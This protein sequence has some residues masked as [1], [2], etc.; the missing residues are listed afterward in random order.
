[1]ADFI[2]WWR[3]FNS[4]ALPTL[5]NID[6]KTTITKNLNRLL[7]EDVFTFRNL[8]NIYFDLSSLKKSEE[9]LIL[10]I[11]K[12]L[13]R[14]ENILN[15]FLAHLLFQA[16]VQNKL[17]LKSLDYSLMEKVIVYTDS[18]LQEFDS[19]Q[20]CSIFSCLPCLNTDFSQTFSTAYYLV[21]NLHVNLMKDFEK[22]DENNILFIIKAYA[23]EGSFRMPY[24]LLFEIHQS[25]C[26]IIKQNP[27]AFSSFFLAKYSEGFLAI[28]KNKGWTDRM[29]NNTV[30]TQIMERIPNDEVLLAF[31]NLEVFL[32]FLASYPQTDKIKEYYGIILVLVEKNVDNLY[33]IYNILEFFL[34]RGYD[35]SEILKK[36]KFNN[37]T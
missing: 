36:V 35:V 17:G 12:F 9:K 19:R 22:L 4:C 33:F 2:F 18:N 10:K 21:K 14:G 26:K 1:M 37:F 29:L 7:D 13:K 25:V 16:F 32:Q 28:E 24:G 31:K 5:V 34:F 8:I 6:I 27:T 11:L 15:P 3:R 23:N 30:L 20:K